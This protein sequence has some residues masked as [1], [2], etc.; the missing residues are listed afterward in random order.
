MAFFEWSDSF[1]V[2]HEEMDSQHKTLVGYV[3]EFYEACEE[4]QSYQD[5]LK[6]FDNI[7]GYTGFHF[8]AEEELMEQNNF[9]DLRT[10][11]IIH[12]Q[13]VERVVDYRSRLE[14]EE[15]YIAEQIRNF[16]KMWLSSH[17]KG[18]D[19]KYSTYV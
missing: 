17:I 9:P 12:E 4:Q 2:K 11:K 18:I 14:K 3:N 7:V 1:S 16:L 8:K 6:L 19:M 10:H 13:L 5:L 15:P